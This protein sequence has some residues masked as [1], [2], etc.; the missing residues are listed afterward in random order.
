MKKFKK[1]IYINIP[2]SH[3]IVFGVYSVISQKEECTFER[4]VKECFTL[5]P[6]VFGMSRYPQWP[7]TLRFDRDL[8]TL[9]ERG[10]ITGNPKTSFSLTKFGERLAK[11]T[12]LF[13]KKGAVEKKESKIGKRGADI[14]WITYL[15]KSEAFQ[16]FLKEEKNFLITEME[17]R[18]LMRCT[19]ETPLRILKQ[20][21][22][23]SKNLA[24]EFKEP[25][26]IEFLDV[27]SKKLNIK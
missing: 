13:L 6:E 10:L 9:R 26:L 14:N 7:D 24:K 21:L 16:R 20:N 1:G 19:L 2:K 8:R 27:C 12:E 15:K 4:L 5:F 23:Y 22:Q 3:L 25:K 11:E 18:N 17:F